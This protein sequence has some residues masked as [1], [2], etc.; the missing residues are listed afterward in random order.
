MNKNKDKKL[1]NICYII[2]FIIR[3]IIMS[4]SELMNTIILYCKIPFTEITGKFKIQSSL[5]ISQFLEYVNI[6]IR[7][8]LNINQ[9]YDIEV[10]EVDSGELGVS[11][12]S[13]D[14]ET[15][16]QRYKI[17]NG[18]FVCYIRPVHPITRVFVRKNDYSL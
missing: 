12:Q 14:E 17:I 4:T 1:K 7:N 3:I 18:C 2:I 5:T 11:I 8:K 15:I 10:V 16:N 13:N 6:H 9:I